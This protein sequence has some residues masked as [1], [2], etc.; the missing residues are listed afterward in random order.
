MEWFYADTND[1]QISIDEGEL[2]ELAEDGTIEPST[3]VWN[4]TL[5][6]WRPA[7]EVRP[8]LFGGEVSPPALSPTRAQAATAQ[9]TRLPEAAAPTSGTAVCSLVFGILGLGTCF[10]LFSL[11]AVICGHIARK[12]AREEIV[13]SSNGG[14]ALAGLITGYAALIVFLVVVAVWAAFIIIAAANGEFET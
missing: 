8:D 7:S 3:L 9:S 14:L 11:T 12:R 6:D 2:S 10:P 4:E 13:P 1:R 5:P